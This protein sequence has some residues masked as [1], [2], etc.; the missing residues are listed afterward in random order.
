MKR[1]LFKVLGFMLLA[2]TLALP[3]A[4]TNVKA[5]DKM[6][7]DYFP[8]GFSK[9]KPE[10]LTIDT[11]DPV[12]VNT[13]LKQNEDML[14]F[15]RDY[16]R[17]LVKRDEEDAY[18]SDFELKYNIHSFYVGFQFDYSVDGSDWQYNKKWD[19]LDV[20][21]P[22]DGF[23]YWDHFGLFYTDNTGNIGL[24]AAWGVESKALKKTVKYSDE[25]DSE[26]FD[27]KNHTFKIRYR[28]QIQYLYI[29]KTLRMR[30]I[31]LRIK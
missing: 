11:N 6:L 14:T 28:Y 24:L 16:D 18:Y 23:N 1:R 3:F 10:K 12:Y 26:I 19:N 21:Y 2:F 27:L 5:A 4:S 17:S 9:L 20:E 8:Y 7:E 31:S 15:L 22:E 30:M 25:L 13:I 29:M